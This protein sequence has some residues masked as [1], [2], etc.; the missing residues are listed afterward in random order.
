MYAEEVVRSVQVVR[1][2]RNREKGGNRLEKDSPPA[3][4]AFCLFLEERDANSLSSPEKHPVDK[5]P[6]VKQG[7]GGGKNVFAPA[8][9]ADREGKKRGRKQ[10]AGREIS[11]QRGALYSK[12]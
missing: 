5:K 4:T 12:E 10:G 6:K 2:C 7:G 1:S 3:K 8:Q 9:R 11:I